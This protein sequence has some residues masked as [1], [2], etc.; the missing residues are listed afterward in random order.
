MDS[1]RH[2]LA[3]GWELYS[4]EKYESAIKCNSSECPVQNY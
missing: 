2:R 4:E 3:L 1:G